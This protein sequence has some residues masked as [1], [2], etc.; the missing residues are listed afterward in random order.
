MDPLNLMDFWRYL[1]FACIPNTVFIK[2]FYRIQSRHDHMM[3]AQ[4][5]IKYYC[6]SNHPLFT[7]IFV[8][9]HSLSKVV[10]L[11]F[12]KYMAKFNG[13]P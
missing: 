6:Q 4:S 3:P 9:I 10:T 13:S 5:Q 2:N 11:S 1:G 12:Y 8:D 7:G